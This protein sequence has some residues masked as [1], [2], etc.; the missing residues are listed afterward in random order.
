[1]G[2]KGSFG[3]SSKGRSHWAQT[4]TPKLKNAHLAEGA[5]WAQRDH[6]VLMKI[7]WGVTG[8]IGVKSVHLIYKSL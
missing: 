3:L 7:V 6:R 5:H 1:M 4:H 2:S 8:L